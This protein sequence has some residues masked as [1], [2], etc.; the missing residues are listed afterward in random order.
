MVQA[1]PSRDRE[2]PRRKRPPAVELTDGL[3]GPDKR[4][5]GDI[6]RIAISVRAKHL[7]N[8]MNDPR[9]VS[10][11]E[12]GKALDA[13]GPRPSGKLSIIEIFEMSHEHEFTE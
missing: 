11:R 2:E 9:L 8:V 4:F 6:I 7:T 5:L 10:T 1:C 3:P 13:P 12:F